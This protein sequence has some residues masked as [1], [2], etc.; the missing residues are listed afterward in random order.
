M[1]SSRCGCVQFCVTKR[2][3]MINIPSRVEL[4]SEWGEDRFRKALVNLLLLNPSL[5]VSKKD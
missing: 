4:L 5:S 3:D 2:I 1:E